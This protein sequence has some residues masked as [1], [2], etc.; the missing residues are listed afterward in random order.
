MDRKAEQRIA[1]GEIAVA[2]FIE[3]L[4]N[5]LTRSITGLCR[6]ANDGSRTEELN[7]EDA[8]M[9]SSEPKPRLTDGSSLKSAE[10]QDERASMVIAV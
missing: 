3:A 8:A 7:D 10:T 2:D 9:A 6:S 4:I 1:V 5:Q